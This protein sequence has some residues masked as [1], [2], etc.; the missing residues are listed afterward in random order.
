[1]ILVLLILCTQLMIP[2]AFLSIAV[3]RLATV[4]DK[5]IQPTFPICDTPCHPL[6]SYIPAGPLFFKGRKG[7]KA[8]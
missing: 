3:A 2:I 5:V 4:A 6:F 7:G 8:R 1:M